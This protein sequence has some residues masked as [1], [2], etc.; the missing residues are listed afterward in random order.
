MTVSCSHPKQAMMSG[1]SCPTRNVEAE[2]S[3]RGG[4]T[5]MA[6]PVVMEGMSRREVDMPI[7]SCTVMEQVG[8]VAQPSA[9][10]ALSRGMGRSLR[11]RRP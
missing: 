5:E 3:A 9:G 7:Y 2:A 11:E 6:R 4:G 8:S 10:R 1:T